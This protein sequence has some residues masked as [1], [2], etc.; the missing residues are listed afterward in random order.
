[1]ASAYTLA[2]R[3]NN[4]WE[5]L[6][7]QNNVI[8]FRKTLQPGNTTLHLCE[9]PGE[10]VIPGGAI[11]SGERP[12]HAALRLFCEATRIK[13]PHSATVQ[14]FY[15]IGEDTYFWLLRAEDNLWMTLSDNEELRKKNTYFIERDK[16]VSIDTDTGR[17][18]SSWSWEYYGEIHMLQWSPISE[19]LTKFDPNE[20]LSTWQENQYIIAK[21]A[22]PAYSNYKLIQ[23]YH[24]ERMFP[25][26]S[27]SAIQHLV[28]NPMLTNIQVY[29]D[30]ER[31]HPVLLGGSGQIIYSQ[32]MT[33]LKVEKF[34]TIVEPVLGGSYFVVAY[35]GP[36]IVL[37]QTLHYIGNSEGWHKFSSQ[38]Y[39]TESPEIDAPPHL[40]SLPPD[41]EKHE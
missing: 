6:L 2:I 12:G 15:S 24:N 11:Q 27:E 16:A 17:L 34:T 36:E 1:M 38:S 39:S 4:G 3:N 26:W 30:Y 37:F 9:H 20:Q 22:M 33:H 32:G 10:Y 23:V 18:I 7:A 14:Q 13:R 35:N 31:K 41:I 5:V 40:S 28:Q 19:A 25:V 8:D 21:Q 29:Q